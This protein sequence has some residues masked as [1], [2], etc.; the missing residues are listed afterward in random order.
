[1]ACQLDALAKCRNAAARRNVL[2]SLPRDLSETYSRILKQIDCADVLENRMIVQRVLQWVALA[3]PGLTLPEVQEAVVINSGDTS[4][5]RDSITEGADILDLC[6]SLVRCNPI[7]GVLELAHATVKEYLT[8]I[9]PES[10]FYFYRIDKV[11]GQSDLA[12]T[13]LTYICLDDFAKDINLY[14]DESGSE[15][16]SNGEKE[17]NFHF[18]PHACWYWDDYA[19]N[20]PEMEEILVLERRLFAPT[21]VPQFLH[22]IRHRTSDDDSVAESTPLHWAALLGL[23]NTC[24]WLIDQGCDV[25]RSAA[26]LGNS[27][28]CAVTGP[29]ILVDDINQ[30]NAKQYNSHLEEHRTKTISLLLDAHARLDELP[31]RQNKSLM[32]VAITI[33][34]P[35][36]VGLLLKH[37]G[38]VDGGCL[39]YLEEQWLS[40][41]SSPKLHNILKLLSKDNFSAT[42]LPRI[43]RLLLQFEETS[44]KAVKI[45]AENV[46]LLTSLEDGKTFDWNN[47]LRDAA[48]YGQY[49]YALDCF[50]HSEAIELDS[51]D[52]QTGCNA[53]H[54]AAQNGHLEVV[55]LLL[56]KGYNINA[57]NH[58]CETP[59]LVAA[60]FNHLSVF[61]LL[62]EQGA[63]IGIQEK[64]DSYSVVHE[65]ANS[66][67]ISIIRYIGKVKPHLLSCDAPRTSDGKTA[68]MCAARTGGV[69]T[70]QYILE[71]L[72]FQE[73]IAE[74]NN[75][76][77][78][79]HFGAAS[80]NKKVVDML[81]KNHPNVNI[82]S[83]NGSTA[84]H[85]AVGAKRK[86][87]NSTIMKALVD[88]GCNPM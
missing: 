7:T 8:T 34:V 28:V 22:W 31:S 29:A 46:G 65:A 4:L 75:G 80:G 47:A 10:E 77:S 2:K 26:G 38:I 83:K 41:S 76:N 68:L 11:K 84:L 54:F 12:I 27:L 64:R 30:P 79:L 72:P 14:E 70:V 36:Q 20:F 48:E 13:C 39:E 63:D 58:D 86:A 74:S 67:N 53:L 52:P 1:V 61:K 32:E 9:P 81:L 82:R 51:P 69:K 5:D 71:T 45:L 88:A 37:G 85:Y 50:V 25:N 6:S 21:K 16:D 33:G 3:K 23:Y 35:E 18:L 44:E 19:E 40:D 55:Q 60:R 62:Y 73:V 24:Q 87:L 66:D 15:I 57:L 49:A 59:A 42:D 17:S 43:S 78:S 56:E